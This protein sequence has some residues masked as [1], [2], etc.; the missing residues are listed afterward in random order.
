VLG[1]GIAILIG[2]IVGN[3]T[4][5][6]IGILVGL[7]LGLAALVLMAYCGAK[8]AMNAAV[9]A[10]LAFQELVNQPESVAE[11][12]HT[13]RP[14]LWRFFWLQG[15]LVLALIATQLG[16]A[17]VQGILNIPLVLVMGD[18]ILASLLGLILNLGATAVYY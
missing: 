17:I 14:R 10:R 18:N 7:G 9:I 15:L 16:T 4:V 5:P 11:A 2:G 3:I 6:A 13:L 12:R 1:L 8:S